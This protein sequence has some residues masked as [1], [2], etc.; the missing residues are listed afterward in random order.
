MEISILLIPVT[1]Q[2]WVNP[3]RLSAGRMQALHAIAGSV[4]HIASEVSLVTSV[5]RNLRPKSAPNGPPNSAGKAISA[6]QRSQLDEHV[7]YG[8]SLLDA[9]PCK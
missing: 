5:S 6:L 4:Q 2:H 3:I 1:I 7:R 9:M 8:P